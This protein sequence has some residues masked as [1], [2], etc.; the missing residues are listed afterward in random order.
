M[1]PPR[2]WVLVEDRGAR[3]AS[4]N[5]TPPCVSQAHGRLNFKV[6]THFVL[7]I[8][9]PPTRPPPPAT[10]CCSLRRGQWLGG[11]GSCAWGREGATLKDFTRRVRNLPNLA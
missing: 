8:A 7:V 6:Y 9:T 11:R 1:I 10:G 2:V 3:V 5:L 4:V